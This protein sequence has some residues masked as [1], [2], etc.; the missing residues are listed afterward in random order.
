MVARTSELTQEHVPQLEGLIHL[1]PMARRASA[2]TM[3]TGF[4]KVPQIDAKDGNWQFSPQ[5]FLVG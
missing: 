3:A 2:T 4:G 5:Q 1:G